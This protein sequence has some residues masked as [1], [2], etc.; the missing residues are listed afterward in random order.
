MENVVRKFGFAS[1]G[2]QAADFS[3]ADQVIQLGVAP[4]RIVIL[5]GLTG[6]VF[7]EAWDKRVSFTLDGL[8]LPFLDRDSLRA[9][10]Q[11]TGRSQDIADLEALE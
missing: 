2:L 3:T 8:V 10:K 1:T 5:T 9:N 11:A 4:H 7:S 6:L